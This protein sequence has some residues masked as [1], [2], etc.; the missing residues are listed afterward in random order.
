MS[1]VWRKAAPWLSDAE[2]REDVIESR[3][4][5]KHYH[6]QAKETGEES[7]W[8]AH[9]KAQRS[10][11]K[12]RREHAAVLAQ[13]WV[14]VAA[15]AV[16]VGAVGFVL[17]TMT[18]RWMPAA[19]AIAVSVATIVRLGVVGARVASLVVEDHVPGSTPKHITCELVERAFSHLRIAAL[20]SAPVKCLLPGIIEMPDGDGWKVTVELPAGVTAEQDVIPHK[21]RFASAIGGIK[22]EQVIMRKGTG[23]NLLVIEV[24]TVPPSERK[25]ATSPYLSASTV[26]VTDPIEWGTDALGSPTSIRQS[27]ATLIVGESGKGKSNGLNNV[28]APYALSPN[29]RIF[30]ATFKLSADL[31]SLLDV[32]NWPIV[33][34][35]DR[36]RH[37][38]AETV[39]ML[40][41]VRDEA[42]RRGRLLTKDHIAEVTDE[43]TLTDPNFF[44]FLV[45]V[46][47]SQFLIRDDEHGAQ[48][49]KFI[50]GLAE[51]I[52]YTGIKLVFTTQRLSSSGID[53]NFAGIF[54]TRVVYKASNNA[55]VTTLCGNDAAKLGFDATQYYRKGQCVL[56]GDDE[57]LKACNA[58]HWTGEHKQLLKTKALAMRGGVVEKLNRPSAFSASNEEPKQEE[59]QAS[60]TRPTDLMAQIIAIRDEGTFG[61]KG[62]WSEEFPALC[63]LLDIDEV[64]LRQALKDAEVKTV[65]IAKNAANKRGFRFDHITNTKEQAS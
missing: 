15:V 54:P 11:S 51:S 35:R 1:I 30:L 52:R 22:A 32:A 26:R 29:G 10:C 31:E 42:T 9:R 3:D 13:H 28:A 36:D 58:Y 46:D 39:R 47:E 18:P 55:E 56:V 53:H 50:D 60:T 59:S 23:E 34:D 8:E 64:T 6:R 44:P 17:W 2:G 24:S 63:K 4:S 21:A 19:L 37:A 49:K 57:G 65:Q 5:K 41:A 27:H 48:M 33:G 38:L 20:N 45:I 14:V 12:L 40:T 25:P 62:V 7:A 43:M 61:D 16:G